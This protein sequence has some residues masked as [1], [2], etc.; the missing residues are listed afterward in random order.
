MGNQLNL[1]DQIQMKR[2]EVFRKHFYRGVKER[3]EKAMED[4]RSVKFK[5]ISII[6]KPIQK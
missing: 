5:R 2:Y 1:F 6:P 3:Q 4:F